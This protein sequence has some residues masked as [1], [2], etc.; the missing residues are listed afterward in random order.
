MVAS[1]N[2]P[3]IAQ[4]YGLETSPS[5]FVVMELVDGETL[6]AR[7]K[8]R[9]PSEAAGRAIPISEALVIASQIVDALDT[10][11]E[12]AESGLWAQTAAYREK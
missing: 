8:P 4:I 5:P 10:A 11:H 2:H 12:R 1:L 6:D 9:A 3:H 7:L